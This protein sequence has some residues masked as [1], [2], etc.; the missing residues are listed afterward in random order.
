MARCT[1]IPRLLWGGRVVFLVFLAQLRVGWQ[2]DDFPA[3]A[4]FIK[5]TIFYFFFRTTMTPG[6]HFKLK[7]THAASVWCCVWNPLPDSSVSSLSTPP[8]PPSP[9]PTPDSVSPPRWFISPGCVL[10]TSRPPKGSAVSES[11]VL[12]IA[13]R[14]SSGAPSSCRT[15]T[16]SFKVAAPVLYAQVQKKSHKHTKN[17]HCSSCC[18]LCLLCLVLPSQ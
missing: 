14:C 8:P 7:L 1:V 16:I 2:C 9:P 6:V 5:R 17:C 11:P 4:R 10:S 18:C 3:T 12:S 13:W 15:M